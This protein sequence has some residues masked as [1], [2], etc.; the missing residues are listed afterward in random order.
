MYRHFDVK[1][2]TEICRSIQDQ[3]ESNALCFLS[4]LVI[5][6]G[7]GD[8]FTQSKLEMCTCCAHKPNSYDFCIAANN[9]V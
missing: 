5:T 8:L 6:R 1:Y 9:A 4:M 7:E 3:F 2:M